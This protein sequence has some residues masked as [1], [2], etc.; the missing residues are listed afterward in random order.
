MFPCHQGFICQKGQLGIKSVTL[1][2]LNLNGYFHGNDK[3]N[4]KMTEY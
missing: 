3:T 4:N 2:V 1:L